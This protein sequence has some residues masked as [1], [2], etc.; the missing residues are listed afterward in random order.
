M[1]DK[2]MKSKMEQLE[3]AI[4]TYNAQSEQAQRVKRE[5]EALLGKQ[6]VDFRDFEAKKK[7]ELEDMDRLRN[8]ELEK[9]RKEKKL[10]EQR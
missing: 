7:R 4:E 5:Y 1:M 9:V 8:E 2:V 6:R 10:L 3:R